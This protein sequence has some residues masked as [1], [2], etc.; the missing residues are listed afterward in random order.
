MVELVLKTS[1]LYSTYFIPRSSKVSPNIPKKRPYF[2]PL[3]SD[4][5]DLFH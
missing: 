4:Y 3:K 2:G 5:I 1:H